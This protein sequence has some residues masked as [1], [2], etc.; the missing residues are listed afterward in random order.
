MM[1]LPV[2]A[3]HAKKPAP[4]L[5]GSMDLQFDL[6]WPGYQQE[7]PDWIGTITINKIEYG[8]VFFAFETGKPFANPAK[9]G[10]FF[11]GEK[12]VIYD[13]LD[14]EFDEDGYLMYFDPGQELLWGYDQGVT[15]Q[16]SKYHMTGNVEEAYGIFSMWEGRNVYMSGKIIWQIVDTPEGPIVMPHYAPGSF[17]IN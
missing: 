11:F 3:V 8:M 4:H 1:L 12:W 17:R 16:N 9:G 15:V 2:M 5:T 10:A 14:F 7:T 6:G 13:T